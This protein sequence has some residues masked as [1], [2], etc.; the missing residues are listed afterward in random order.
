MDEKTEM[1]VDVQEV[2]AGWVFAGRIES[3]T[4]VSGCLGRYV[5]DGAWET[6]VEVGAGLRMCGG[7]GRV[8][9]KALVAWRER[10]AGRAVEEILGLGAEEAVNM[11]GRE[12]YGLGGALKAV[13]PWHS[14]L[15]LGVLVEGKLV[16]EVRF[17][18]EGSGLRHTLAA[19]V[20]GGVGTSGMWRTATPKEAWKRAVAAWD[21]VGTA[22][23]ARRVRRWG[24]ETRK[25][26]GAW[27][28]E[29]C[30][31]VVG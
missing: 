13:Y 9:R 17:V 4:S 23:R 6:R 2:V 10:E 28:V 30:M 16:A 24:R 31:K 15:V 1:G 8:W 21:V 18:R 14:W 25:A 11:C 22:A 29:E 27:C 19:Q 26:L 7:V 12:R 20:E 5:E 3:K